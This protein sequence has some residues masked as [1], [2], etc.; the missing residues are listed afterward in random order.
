MAVG[1]L[2][3]FLRAS[4]KTTAIATLNRQRH[5]TPSCGGFTPTAERTVGPARMIV[6]SLTARPGIREQY[7]PL[8]DSFVLVLENAWAG[9][10][11]GSFKGQSFRARCVMN[12]RPSRMR[13]RSKPWHSVRRRGNLRV[14]DVDYRTGRVDQ[15]DGQKTQDLQ[16]SL[17]FFDLAIAAPSMK[18]A[19]ERGRRQQ[20]PTKALRRR[21]TIRAAS[22]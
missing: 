19:L 8:A 11:S 18:A 14:R 9:S 6:E 3:D 20:S 13:E 12:G 4:Q 17:G 22:P 5:L 10:T 2:T 7:R 16:T 1:S 15:T 21:A